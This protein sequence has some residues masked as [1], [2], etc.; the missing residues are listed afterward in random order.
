M[1]KLQ[2]KLRFILKK[3]DCRMNINFNLNFNRHQRMLLC[4]EGEMAGSPAEESER[5]GCLARVHGP[6]SGSSI[7]Q[8][9]F[10]LR[11]GPLGSGNP[12]E[13]GAATQR[14][15]RGGGGNE[16]AVQY[17]VR[18]PQNQTQEVAWYVCSANIGVRTETERLSTGREG[19]LGGRTFDRKKGRD[20]GRARRKEL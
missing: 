1:K 20:T 17:Q 10:S 7:I 4:K 14:G 12:G 6:S 18:R 2:S 9:V 16:L 3:F 5:D 13:V 8:T 19:G 15:G 11:K